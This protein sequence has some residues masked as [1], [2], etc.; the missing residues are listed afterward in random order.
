MSRFIEKNTTISRVAHRQSIYGVSQATGKER[1]EP[2][3]SPA[4]NRL[5]FRYSY[6]LL[7]LLRISFFS[8]SRYTSTTRHYI[9]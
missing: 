6:K 4:A 2:K 5:A 9:F 1:G 8:I 3:L 7:Y